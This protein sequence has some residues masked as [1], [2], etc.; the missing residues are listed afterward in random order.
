LNMVMVLSI[1]IAASSKQ[2]FRVQWAINAGGQELLASDGIYYQGGY[3]R[4]NERT[5]GIPIDHVSERDSPLYLNIFGDENS[6]NYKIPVPREGNFLL[7]LKWAEIDGQVYADDRIM[8]VVLNGKH[9]VIKNIDIFKKV[10]GFAAHF[11]YVYFSIVDDYLYY[12]REV[13]RIRNGRITIDFVK[14]KGN[15]FISAIVLFEGNVEVIP[16]LPWTILQEQNKCA[17][18]V[19]KETEAL[20]EV[21]GHVNIFYKNK[22]PSYGKL[23]SVG[24]LARNA[25]ISDANTEPA[26]ALS[27]VLEAV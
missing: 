15:P 17:I 13:S 12:K 27:E 19:V 6:F 10:G 14:I 16:K 26:T 9:K 21:N 25:S 3:K 7:V 24:K 4:Q 5:E 23:I 8:D 20:I 11:E 1:G 18:K 2:E 22:E